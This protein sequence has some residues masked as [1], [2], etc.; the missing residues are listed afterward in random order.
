MWFFVIFLDIDYFKIFNDCFGYDIGDLVLK[1]LVDLLKF[2]C[3]QVDMV[4]CW[5]G[6]EF[7][8]LCFL[9]DFVD[10]VKFVELFCRRIELYV[11]SYVGMVIVLFGVVGFLVKQFMVSLIKMVDNVFY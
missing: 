9:I 7:L 2:F 4:V 3:W 5:G 11:F 1:E 10:V 8:I 6:E